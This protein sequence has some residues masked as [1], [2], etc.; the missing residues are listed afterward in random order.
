M[1]KKYLILASL[2][3][4]VSFNCKS[5]SYDYPLWF[6]A[7]TCKVLIEKE[8]ISEINRGLI[9]YRA[10]MNFIMSLST[11]LN[12]RCIMVEKGTLNPTNSMLYADLSE[13]NSTQDLVIVILNYQKK[14]PHFSNQL[15][16]VHASKALSQKWPCKDKYW[17]FKN[18]GLARINI[19]IL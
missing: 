19:I 7:D 11:T 17:N 4:A 18:I 1:I 14:N 8:K 3:F 9:N 5:E 13:V 12:S 15:A 16:W 6:I 10:C 2:I